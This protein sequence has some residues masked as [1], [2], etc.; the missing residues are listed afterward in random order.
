[1]KEEYDCFYPTSTEEWRAWLAENHAKKDSI[2][3]IF[4]KKSSKEPSITWSE[5]VDEA[6]CFGWIDSLKKTIDERSY[7][8][9]FTPR[10]PKSGWSKIN[11]EK[12]IKLTQ[13]KK[14]RPA[15]IAAVERAK[16]NGMWELLDKI[17]ALILPSE[18]EATFKVEPSAREFYASLSNSKKKGVLYW[19]ISAKRPATKAK[20]IEEFLKFAAEGKLPNRFG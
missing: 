7:R 11:K 20:R 9:V 5:A 18:L 6:I 17:E 16:Q 15:G 19:V 8:Q 3:V 4:Y 10:K 1:M 13:L 2:W 14:M 12:V